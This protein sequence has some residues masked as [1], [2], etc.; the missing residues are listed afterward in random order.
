MPTYL[1]PGV[2][3]EEIPSGAKTIEGV[4][5][6]TA[7]FIGYTTQ[8]PVGTPLLLLNFDDYRRR[9]GGIRDLGASPLGDALGFS[10]AAF[11]Q[12][13][14][15]K[16][17]VVRLARDDS[18]GHPLTGA[19]AY[20][21][22]PAPPG[23]TDALEFTA[24]SEGQ[25]AN[26]LIVR[27]TPKPGSADLF[28]VDV[29]RLDD[30]GNLR[31]AETYRDVSMDAASPR[32][33]EAVLNGVSPNVGVA[34]QPF[35]D[36]TPPASWLSTLTGTSTSGDLTG[37]DLD[38]TALSAAQ[39]TL[40]M[41]LDAV[42]FTI[43]VPA[44][45]FTD[46]LD[47]L[48][49]AIQ[50]AVRSGAAAERRT[51]FTAVADGTRLVLTSGT[52]GTG[53]SA[54]VDGASALAPT[55]LLGTANGG[56]EVSGQDRLDA[57]VGGTDAEL[58]DGADGVEAHDDAYESTFSALVKV[59]DVNIICLPGKA[60]DSDGQA[61]IQLAV[62]HAEQTTSRMVIVDPP[63]ATELTTELAVANLG[64]PTSTYS[65][66][67]YPWVQVANPFYDEEDNPGVPTT[68]MVPPGGYAAGMWAKIDGRRGV[69]KAPA[70]VET[71][72]LGLSALRFDV[73]D[74]EQDQLNPLGVNALRKLPG[75]GHVI[76][77]TRTLSTRANPEWRYVPVR[78]TAIFIEQSIYNSIQWAVFEPNDHKLWSSLRSNI[79]A[80]M[81]GLWRS[82]A[83]Q[84]EKASDAYFVRC[85]LGDTM[86]QADI[87]RGQVI[88]IVAFAPLKPAEFVIVRIQ[89]KVAQQ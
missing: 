35:A 22:K 36:M 15:T 76:W 63:A 54:V 4:G 13:G 83:F 61:A 26:G 7:A 33:V 62:A 57:R 10:V 20:I 29:G 43:T 32:F 28:T 42:A 52:R 25:W 77:G 81:N 80:F 23:N 46:R 19:R 67:Y 60:W 82:N 48:A 65:V 86:T 66:L 39:R 78:R 12:N 44:E 2:Y 84:G 38:F 8:G 88:V 27:V 45:D 85:G 51:S 34:V 70:G 56:T 89:Q 11:F 31:S 74:G 1:H 69:W 71:N 14:G 37:A 50:A 64:L 5:T 47:D 55:L 79:D 17:Y 18:P 41:S 73:G 58:A 72:L 6:S 68:L 49:A 24:T 53:S 87:D 16:A 21:R 75:F 3:I 59:R 40:G 9:Y 30:R